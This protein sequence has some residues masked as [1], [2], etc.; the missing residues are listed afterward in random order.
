MNI[1]HNIKS[2][3][4]LH[5][6]FTE[7]KRNV[8]IDGLFT[9]IIYTNENITTMGMYFD[10]PVDSYHESK[11]TIEFIDKDCEL[12]NKLSKIET[13]VLNYYIMS[14]NINKKNCR[15]DLH[16]RI[17]D[18]HIKVYKKSG[19]KRMDKLIIKI[20]GVW[21][22]NKDIGITFKLLEGVN[23]FINSSS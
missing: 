5:I 3:D 19:Q 20:S 11:D 18:G 17:L 15:K 9:K 14:C 4:P 1:I 21:E 12:I 13:D 6:N 2:Y 7:A 23:T 16:K 8:I 22:S 10:I